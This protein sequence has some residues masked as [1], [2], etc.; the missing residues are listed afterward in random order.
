[1]NFLT[2]DLISYLSLFLEGLDLW[3]FAVA[4]KKNMEKINFHILYLNKFVDDFEDVE[5]KTTKYEFLKTFF[6]NGKKKK[7]QMIKLYQNI[8]TLIKIKSPK[9]ELTNDGLEQESLKK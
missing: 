5:K 9:N 2:K 6:K 4:S 7:F 3:R 8:L 1:M